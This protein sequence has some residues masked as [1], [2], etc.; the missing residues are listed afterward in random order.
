[1]GVEEPAGN[2]TTAEDGA[3]HEG[4]LRPE[5]TGNG[6]G[7][8]PGEGPQLVQYANDEEGGRRG[9]A[10]EEEEEDEDEQGL[11]R[12]RR[13]AQERRRECPYLDTVNRQVCPWHKE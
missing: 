6:A 3:A 13:Q 10:E 4:E 7:N 5:G 2:G 1:M 9:G 12:R 11:L 8:A